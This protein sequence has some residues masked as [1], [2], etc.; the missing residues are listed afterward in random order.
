MRNNYGKS[1][2]VLLSLAVSSVKPC[3]STVLPYYAPAQ[4]LLLEQL[5]SIWPELQLKQK[6]TLKPPHPPLSLVQCKA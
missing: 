3:R 2:K 1:V 4:V 6:K 5:S